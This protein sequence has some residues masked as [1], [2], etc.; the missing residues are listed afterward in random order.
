MYRTDATV[1]YILN[2]WFETHNGVTP[3]KY[4]DGW[5]LYGVKRLELRSAKTLN[6]DF[7]NPV[8]YFLR[9]ELHNLPQYGD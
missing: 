6:N 4:Y 2:L 1:P 9:K 3:V 7:L 5:Q 8:R